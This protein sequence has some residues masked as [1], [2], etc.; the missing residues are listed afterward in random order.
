MQMR[1]KDQLLGNKLN[2]F[3][4][5]INVKGKHR[6]GVCMLVLIRFKSVSARQRLY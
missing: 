1:N 6:V 3:E 4:D 5:K 2:T